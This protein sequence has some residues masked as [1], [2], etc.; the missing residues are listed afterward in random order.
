[1]NNSET[2]E[3]IANSMIML[4]LYLD[5]I[6]S[7]Q[8]GN[9]FNG[10]FLNLYQ[11]TMT[12]RGRKSTDVYLKIE[13]SLP[14]N[15]HA[16]IVKT[17]PSSIFSFG[18]KASRI[19]FAPRTLFRNCCGHRMIQPMTATIAKFGCQDTGS[20]DV[21]SWDAGSDSNITPST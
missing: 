17:P 15:T 18:T 16:V 13:S 19:L 6:V 20:R 3:V 2:S 10:Q 14:S 11:V 21:G 12:P 5:E 4:L 7:K 1:M 9:H 8:P